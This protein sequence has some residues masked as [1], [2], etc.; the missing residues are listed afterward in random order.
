MAI[1][2]ELNP[3]LEKA[4]TEKAIE[5][6]LST[7][8]YAEKLLSEKLPTRSQRAVAL[9]QSWVDDNETEESQEASE[10][11][12]QSLDESRTSNRKLFPPELKG[13]TW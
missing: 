1:T 12:I 8:A 4:L 13:V 9:L 5:A 2:L 6:G 7:A 10:S 3:E 11:L